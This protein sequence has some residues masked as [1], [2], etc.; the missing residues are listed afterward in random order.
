[1]ILTPV[2]PHGIAKH[3]S[4]LQGY[5]YENVWEGRLREQTI[6]GAEWSNAWA[7]WRGG[8]LDRR[9]HVRR[10]KGR[11]SVLLGF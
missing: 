9:G 6:V 4:E 3:A 5:R 8:P 1:V 11:R 10:D 2:R 7:E